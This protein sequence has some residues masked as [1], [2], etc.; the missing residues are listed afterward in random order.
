MYTEVLVGLL[1]NIA[2]LLALAV[3]YDAIALRPDLSRR[4]VKILCGAAIGA[5]GVAIM[6]HPW[7]LKPGIVFDTRSV[8]LGISGLFFG[9]IPTVI[10]VAVTGLLRLWQGGVGVWM[11]L[12]VIAS[13]GGIGVA[14]RYFRRKLATEPGWLELYAFGISVHLAMVA[15]AVLL[16]GTVRAHVVDRIALPVMLICPVGTVLLGLLLVHQRVREQAR[17]DLRRERDLLRRS[18]ERIRKL[19]RILTVLSNINQS[20]VRIRDMQELFRNACHIAVGDGGFRLAWLGMLGDDGETVQIRAHAPAEASHMKDLQMRVGE[21]APDCAPVAAALR[22]GRHVVVQ[23]VQSDPRVCGQCFRGLDTNTGS[24]AV[25][26]LKVAGEAVGVFGLYSERS[27]FFDDTEEMRLLEELAMDLSFAIEFARREGERDRVEAELRQA[28]KMEAVGKLAGGVSHDFNNMLTVILGY[29]DS[30]LHRLDPHDPVFESV[31]EIRKAGQRSADL[32]RQLLAFSRRQIVKPCP[33]DWNQAIEN[34]RKMLTR[35]LGEDVTLE[36]LPGEDLWNVWIDLSQIDQ[37][38]TNLA[39]NARDA[40]QGVGT[41][42]IETANV[43]LDKTY[44]RRR[45]TWCPAT[46]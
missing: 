24:L 45:A 6:L 11:G 44:S 41:V 19:Y 1:D 8:L 5:I 42:T 20:I 16:P 37:I 38:L 27:G 36:V 30:V 13:S 2:L 39:T 10:G 43:T 25:F 4:V 18:D 9:A 15:C 17:R 32:T 21:S 34:R 40:I 35:L 31:Q 26:P 46:T 7:Q 28:Q 33:V 22:E 23:D 29:A 14:W 3:V 12:A